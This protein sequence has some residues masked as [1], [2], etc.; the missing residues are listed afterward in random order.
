MKFLIFIVETQRILFKESLN[1]AQ[2]KIKTEI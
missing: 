2:Y 1:S